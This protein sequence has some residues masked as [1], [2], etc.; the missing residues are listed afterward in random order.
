MPPLPG[1]PQLDQI[2]RKWLA[3]AER[4]LAYYADLH[5]SGRWRHYYKKTEFAARVREVIKAVQKWRK[6]AQGKT[7]GDDLR[8]AA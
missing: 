7:N 5:R 4:R 8:P 6:L 2:S 1:V 3:L